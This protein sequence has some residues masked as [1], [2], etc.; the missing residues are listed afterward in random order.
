MPGD[1]RRADVHASRFPRIMS[2]VFD[3][4]STLSGRPPG[5]GRYCE[6]EFAIVGTPVAQGF[7]H[8]LWRPRFA[9]GV[10]GSFHYS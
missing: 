9:F 1:R 6:G 4:L 7:A 2:F 8:R 10:P 5:G 3:A